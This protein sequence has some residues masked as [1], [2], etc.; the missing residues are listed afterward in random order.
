MDAPFKVGDGHIWVFFKEHPAQEVGYLFLFC[1]LFMKEG[2]CIS[3]PFGYGNSGPV[4]RNAFPA[5]GKQ[6]LVQ[7]GRKDKASIKGFIRR[8]SISYITHR[9]FL[10]FAIF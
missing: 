4:L 3:L 9:Q 7:L 10:Y 8:L 2:F 6:L 1:G 5:F